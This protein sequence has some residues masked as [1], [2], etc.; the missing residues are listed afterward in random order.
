MRQDYE[1]L[2]LCSGISR[3]RSCEILCS[4]HNITSTVTNKTHGII[5][6]LNCSSSKIIYICEC[7][8]CSKQYVGESNGELRVRM[9]GHRFA[10]NSNVMSSALFTHLLAHTQINKDLPESSLED[11]DLIPIEQL[12]TTGSYIYL[13]YISMFF[14]SLCRVAFSVNRLSVWKERFI[15]L[16]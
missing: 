11:Y 1:T 12:P 13:L 3:C 15:S 14:I 8:R 5:G 4:C 2:P 7:V 9:N 16:V 10:I 6:N